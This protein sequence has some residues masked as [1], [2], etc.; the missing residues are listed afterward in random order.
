MD[1]YATHLPI[2]HKLLYEN[3][4]NSVYEYGCGL[5]STP[6]FINCASDVTS[7][8]MQNEK[9][10]VKVKDALSYAKNLDIHLMLGPDAAIDYFKKQNKSYDLVF[11]DGHVGT[12]WA[13]IN[14]AFKNSKFIVTHDT[15]VPVYQWQ[16]IVVPDGWNEYT[17]NII[18]PHT[19][20]YYKK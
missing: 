2:L 4:I 14:E 5:Y 8:E 16:K 1:R 10:F 17:D 7:I 11:V 20:M 12:R 6:L 18:V 15:E 19:R 3:E 13:C 9:W